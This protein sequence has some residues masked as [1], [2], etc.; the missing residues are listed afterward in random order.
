MR[1]RTL[2]VL[3]VAIGLI[4]AACGGG[5]TSTLPGATTTSTAA[6][7]S[8]LAPTT[9][10]APKVTIMVGGLSKQ[11]YLV[12]KLTEALGN[13]TTQGVDVTLVDEPSGTDTETEIVAGHADIGS[14]SYD[15]TIDLQAQGKIITTI[16]NLLQAPGEF[17]LV[18]TAMA[19][20]IK[21]PADFKGHNIGV[22]SIG[23]GTHTLMRAI[24]VKAGLTV[25]AVTFVKAG[26]G[27]T[28]IAAMK[29]GQID[30]GITTQPTRLQIEKQGV[31][32]LLIDLSKLDTTQAALGGPYPFISLWAKAEWI[33]ANKD[34]VQRVVNA[35]VATLK[36]IQSHSAADITD[37]LPPDYYA[38]D[39]EGYVK[40]L[41]DSM[42]MFNPDGKLSQAALD[43]VLNINKL[44]K[45]GLDNIDL[46]KTYTSEFVDNV[47]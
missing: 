35:Y 7:V 24:T 40:A 4:A 31:G 38:G 36:W 29:Q 46:S 34:T 20:S 3:I 6:P 17:V 11:I 26:A 32:S 33:S 18:S 27:D 21:S 42:G 30:V 37:K 9:A 14:G 8:T 5:A 41:T 28:F 10:S 23:S 43:S 45:P 39:K 44:F 15:H 19:S 12:N 2:P 25:D 22:T 1:H 16:A 47:K 13:F